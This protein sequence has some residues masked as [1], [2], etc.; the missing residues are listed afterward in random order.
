MIWHDSTFIF[1]SYG[2][3]SHQAVD[4]SPPSAAPAVLAMARK[5]IWSWTEALR[6]DVGGYV[7]GYWNHVFSKR[8]TENNRKI[9]IE[10]LGKNFSTFDIFSVPNFGIKIDLVWTVWMCRCCWRLCD[11]R[12]PG[13]S[14]EDLWA[15]AMAWSNCLTKLGR[16]DSC[17]CSLFITV[18][19]SS[20]SYSFWFILY[21]FV[22]CHIFLDITSFKFVNH[23]CKRHLDDHLT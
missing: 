19:C 4:P 2:L 3:V 14:G 5:S 13:D 11:G 18:H 15:S 16:K 22:V 6:F 21:A 20:L 7:T 12:Y 8:K 23:G 17:T 10:R 1:F 9:T